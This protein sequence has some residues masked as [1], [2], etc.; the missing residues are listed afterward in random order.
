[1]LATKHEVKKRP[2]F[3]RFHL[4]IDLQTQLHVHATNYV[5]YKTYRKDKEA[6]QKLVL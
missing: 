1:M 2:Y 5:D 4:S 3:K 6:I